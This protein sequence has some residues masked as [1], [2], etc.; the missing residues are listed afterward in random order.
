MLLLIQTAETLEVAKRVAGDDPLLWALVGAVIVLALVTA[1]L[2]KTSRMDWKEH[3]EKQ[4]QQLESTLTVLKS[5]EHSVETFGDGL[6]R[7]TS[8]VRSSLRETASEVKQHVTIEINRL[9]GMRR[10][11]HS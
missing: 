6:P 11:P 8:D 2:F 10:Q 3:S 4:G 7:V 1:Y 9:E 5:L